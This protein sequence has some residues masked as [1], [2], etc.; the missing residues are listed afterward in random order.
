MLLRLNI[1]SLVEIETV[2]ALVRPPVTV[3]PPI[4]SV[5]TPSRQQ[6]SI[7]TESP[8]HDS[9]SGVVKTRWIKKKGKKMSVTKLRPSGCELGWGRLPQTGPAVPALGCCRKRKET[10]RHMS[11]NTRFFRSLWIL[12]GKKYNSWCR[13]IADVFI[14]NSFSLSSVEA[15]WRQCGSNAV[16]RWCRWVDVSSCQVS[17]RLV[18]SKSGLFI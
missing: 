11:T 1:C 17:S 5:K 10:I 2:L 13:I 16:C 14:S 7:G 8:L 3:H 9:P 6:R 4:L 15:T 18:L 12:I